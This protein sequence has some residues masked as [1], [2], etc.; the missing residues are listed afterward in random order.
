MTRWGAVYGLRS[1]SL[2]VMDCDGTITDGMLPGK[3]FNTKDGYGIRTLNIE[4]AIISGDT[5]D[6]DI[7]RVKHLGIGHVYTGVM[8]KWRAVK[9]LAEKL[10]IDIRDVC[11]IGDDINDLECIRNCGVG[12]AVH[13]AVKEVRLAADIVTKKPGGRGAVRE[14]T[15]LIR[16]SKH[17]SPC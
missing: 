14:L 5:F 1:V 11:Y 4:K 12:V 10:G 6:P 9:T 13:D 8:N 2:L 15:D 16:R 3:R 7:L 17:E